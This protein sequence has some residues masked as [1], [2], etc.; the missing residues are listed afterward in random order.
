M[1]HFMPNTQ[2]ETGAWSL[3]PLPY[4]APEEE[5]AGRASVWKFLFL[6]TTKKGFPNTWE[7]KCLGIPFFY[8]Q[9]KGIPMQMVA[10]HQIRE[11]GRPP[12]QGITPPRKSVLAAAVWIQHSVTFGAL[13]GA[14]AVSN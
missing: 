7:V 8:N 4:D 13:W 11:C 14:L 5:H 12:S 9:K 3:V 10:D 6:T 2:R 1:E